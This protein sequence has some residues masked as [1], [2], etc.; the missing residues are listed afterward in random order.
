MGSCFI[1]SNQLLSY[2]QTRTF[3]KQFVQANLIYGKSTQMSFSFNF[4][5]F[6][7]GIEAEETIRS[8][9]STGKK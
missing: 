2:K 7:S 5:L 3:F 8:S 4:K 9:T 6:L 1:T